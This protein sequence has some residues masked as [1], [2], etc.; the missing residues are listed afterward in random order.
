MFIHMRVKDE[1]PNIRKAIGTVD[2]D[3]YI[4]NKVC[5]AYRHACQISINIF[6]AKKLT[7]QETQFKCQ[8]GI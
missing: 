5:Y 3:A 4:K 2:R 7:L 8:E 6:C 1:R